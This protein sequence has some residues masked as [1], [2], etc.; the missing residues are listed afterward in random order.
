MRAD[1]VVAAVDR[2]DVLETDVLAVEK[3]EAVV[4]NVACGQVTDDEVPA[5]AVHQT[6]A[7]IL[8]RRDT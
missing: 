6:L 3:I 5:F 2:A 8:P 4:V 1:A 7:S